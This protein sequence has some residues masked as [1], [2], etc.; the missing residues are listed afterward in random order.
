[1][2]YSIRAVEVLIAAGAYLNCKI[3]SDDFRP[4]LIEAILHD[5]PR[6]M[7]IRLLIQGNRFH[8]W[9]VE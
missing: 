8:A 4:P 7:V 6:I 9:I 5:K 1:M 3:I 2:D